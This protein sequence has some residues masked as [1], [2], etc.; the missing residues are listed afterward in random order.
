MFNWLDGQLVTLPDSMGDVQLHEHIV[1]FADIER[2]LEAEQC[3]SVPFV[4]HE[5]NGLVNSSRTQISIT[6][7]VSSL[8]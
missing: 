2:L 6:N 7:W 8:V 4:Q 5:T 1:L 3:V